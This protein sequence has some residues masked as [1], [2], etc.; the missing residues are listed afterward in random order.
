MW[1]NVSVHVD[2]T[3][4]FPTCNI[5]AG[6]VRKQSWFFLW[7]FHHLMICNSTNEQRVSFHVLFIAVFVF[8]CFSARHLRTDAVSKLDIEKFHRA[9][10]KPIYPRVKG[11]GHEAQDKHCRRGS[12]HSHE[13]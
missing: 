8:V 7:Q 11:Q 9:S 3:A 1:S 2:T 12:L 4:R 13:C 10:W 6:C 5:A